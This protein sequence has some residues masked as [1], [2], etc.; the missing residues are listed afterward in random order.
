MSGGGVRVR[1]GQ[2]RTP[3]RTLDE[4]RGVVSRGGW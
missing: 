1:R 4:V 2:V 3:D